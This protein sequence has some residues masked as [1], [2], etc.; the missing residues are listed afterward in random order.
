MLFPVEVWVAAVPFIHPSV[1][2]TVD[3]I[4]SVHKNQRKRCF[5]ACLDTQP[6]GFSSWTFDLISQS[7]M[8]ERK[9]FT[10]VRFWNQTA[11]THLTLWNQERWNHMINNKNP[12]W[13]C[14][15][16][17]IFS[18]LLTYMHSFAFQASNTFHCFVVFQAS[19]QSGLQAGQSRTR[20]WTS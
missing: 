20:T 8:T 3:F 11:K 1:L 13:I 14:L 7:F 19:G 12:I 6:E 15:E 4:S 9:M 10:P 16:T 2:S 17:Q 5:Q 18:Y